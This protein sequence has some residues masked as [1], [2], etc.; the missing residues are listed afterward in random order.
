MADASL[1]LS[2]M[3]YVP[4]PHYEAGLSMKLMSKVDTPLENAVTCGYNF[5]ETVFLKANV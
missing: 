1:L 3:T 5:L 4:A 2:G